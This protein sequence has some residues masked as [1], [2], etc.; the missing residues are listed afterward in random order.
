MIEHHDLRHEFPEHVDRI[1]ELDIQPT[2]D[3]YLEERKRERVKLKD[4]LYAML[5]AR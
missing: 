4:A 3:E 2:G 1:H 5:E